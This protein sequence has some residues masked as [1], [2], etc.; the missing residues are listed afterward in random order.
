ML[1]HTLLWASTNPFLAER[2]P[3][4]RFVQKATQRFMPGEELD[5]ALREA[6]IL[7]EA[8]L[9]STITLLGEHLT[10][11]DEADAVVEHYIGSLG[12]IEEL[13]LDT[14]ISIKPTQI[15]LD[16]GV[17]EARRRLDRLAAATSS[18]VWV[19]MESSEY[20]DATLEMYSS[21]RAERDNVGL[22]LQ[23][24]L[25][26]T[27]K[28]L[29]A[30]LPLDPAIRLVKGAYDEPPS[31]AFPRK[32]DADRNFVKLSQT[33]L[34]A[35]VNG[36]TGRPVIGTHDPRMIS[37]AGRIA[38]ELGL[39]KEQYE[40]AMLFGIQRAEQ[41]RLVR[42]GHPVRVLVSYGAAWFPWYMRRLAERPANLWFVAKQLVG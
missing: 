37:E 5:D 34:R 21:V 18:L 12:R 19:D 8:G 38:H 15:G 27:E 42:R 1:R 11:L 13:G 10:S 39:P 24:Y 20:V 16:F 28:D 3:R 17:A 25:R 4:Y 40:I 22:C 26:R 2:L 23:S 31:V 29:E 35:R 30:L 33:L 9:T 7:G 41:K 6:A 36:G 32:A 14:E